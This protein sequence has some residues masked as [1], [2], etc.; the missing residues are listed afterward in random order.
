MA[1]NPK[2]NMAA[3][4]IMNFGKSVIFGVNYTR[5]ENVDLQTKFG[6]NILDLPL[7][8]SWWATFYLPVA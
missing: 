5:A 2:S 6:G 3:A 7:R 1:K 8:Q 4:A